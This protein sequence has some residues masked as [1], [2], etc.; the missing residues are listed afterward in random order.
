[1]R[2]SKTPTKPLIPKTD[3]KVIPVEKGMKDDGTPFVKAVVLKGAKKSR[4]KRDISK[5][6]YKDNKIVEP[7]LKPAVLDE[8]LVASPTHAISVHKKARLVAG[9]GIKI[10][11]RFNAGEARV[12][13]RKW[14][15]ADPEQQKKLD[16]KEYDEAKKNLAAFK[17]EKERLQNWLD[18]ATDES[19]LLDIIENFWADYEAFGNG[20]LEIRRDDND[21]VAKIGHIPSLRLKVVQGGEKFA[22][23]ATPNQ[24]NPEYFKRFGD[25]RHLNAK[26][27]EWREWKGSIDDDDFDAG[28]D[29]GDDEANEVLRYLCYN[30][31]DM[32]YG[33]PVWYSA[34]ADMIGAIES[35][36]FMLK[37]F[38]EK[39][40]PMY[41]VLLE[42]GSWSDE[43]IATIQNF[44]RR[45]LNGNYHAT[46]A[47]E[48]P[49]NG[50][51]T[52]E[53]ISQEPR[54]WPFILKYRDTVRDII[55]SVHG[56]TPSLVGVI[57]TAHLGGGD[58]SAQMEM[59]KTA[60]IKPRQEK[61][62]W[63]MNQK[64]IKDGMGLSHVMIKFDEIDVKDESATVQSVNTLY[65]SPQRPAITTNEAREMLR[66]APV[67]AEWA[68][69]LLLQ[70][71]QFGLLPISQISEAVRNQ[72]KSAQIAGQ[73]QGIES[74]TQN[75]DGLPASKPT[76]QP[77]QVPDFNSIFSG[78]Q[79]SKINLR[80]E[81]RDAIK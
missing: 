46:L 17:L 12:K 79:K 68:D 29:W 47:L 35:R 52:F 43:T 65:S 74:Q 40:V 69:E 24:I 61:L 4:V 16:K 2:K 15:N 77:E 72:A 33:I 62:E 23:F 11:T 25:P 7:Y 59:V 70:D 27:G 53:Q 22:Y 31:R 75:V 37:F 34:L 81:V 3:I 64:L 66:L 26:T 80:K 20:N 5:S 78:L 56:L 13:M 36:D 50:K 42:G 44:F 73:A 32:N 45:E 38:T 55:V 6:A 8:F 48:V 21:E 10:I 51:I 49:E 67:D 57:E 76:G 14:E 58:G 71:P 9:L 28:K 54:W 18:S 1:M 60:E 19:I 39:A 41:A 30:S 63:L